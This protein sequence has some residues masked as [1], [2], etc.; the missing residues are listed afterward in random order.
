VIETLARTGNELAPRVA[1]TRD[2]ISRYCGADKGERNFEV[3]AHRLDLR[4]LERRRGEQQ[5]VIVAAGEQA[6][7][8]ERFVRAAGDR[9]RPRKAVP[10]ELRAD[11]G[12]FQ[13][14]TEIGEQ[15]VGDV[16]RAARKAAQPLAQL[17]ARLG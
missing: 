15:P 10:E 3:L 2:G 12:R 16:D 1:Q 9:P 4:A 8:G 5:L 17:D 11:A 14:M 13:D 6:I 7:V